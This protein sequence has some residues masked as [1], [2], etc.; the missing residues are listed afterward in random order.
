MISA[1]GVDHGE[2]AK[3][4][5]PQHIAALKR[6]EDAGGPRWSASKK[7]AMALY[8]RARL[9]AHRLQRIHQQPPRFRGSG[10]PIRQG[11]RANMTRA[12]RYNKKFQRK[13]LP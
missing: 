8:A 5:K 11:N 9:S 13:E 4:L 3:S 6:V 2:V 10:R 12:M 1:F 7:D